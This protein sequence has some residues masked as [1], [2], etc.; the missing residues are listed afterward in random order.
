[1]T[2]ESTVLTNLL[3]GKSRHQSGK[4]RVQKFGRAH[5]LES[6]KGDNIELPSHSESLCHWK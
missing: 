1:M 6:D 2:I 3:C 5:L 4:N